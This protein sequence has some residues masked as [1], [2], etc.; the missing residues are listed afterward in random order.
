MRPNGAQCA[1][2]AHNE[3]LLHHEQERHG[4][5]ASA[6]VRSPMTYLNEKHKRQDSVGDKKGMNILL[7]P[8]WG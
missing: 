4:Y 6:S 8:C 1:L 3:V 2:M 5:D 7:K